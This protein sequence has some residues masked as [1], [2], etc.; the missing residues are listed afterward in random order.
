MANWGETTASAFANS[1]QNAQKI[2]VEKYIKENENKLAMAA[3]AEKFKE[4]QGGQSVEMAK[5]GYN[6]ITDA[7]LTAP[8]QTFDTKNISTIPNLGM[9]QYDSTKKPTLMNTLTPEQTKKLAEMMASGDMAPMQIGPRNI[10]RVQAMLGAK[11]INPNFSPITADLSYVADKSSMTNI[12]TQDTKVN[13]GNT[14]MKIFNSNY[15]SETDTY[16]IPPSLHYEIAMGLARM[17][18][19]TGVVAQQTAE[20]LRQKTAREGLAGAAIYLGFDPKE[21]GGS[22]Q[23]LIRYFIKN[24][25]T[26]A[27]EAVRARGEYQKGK[28]SDYVGIQNQKEVNQRPSN[29]AF[30]SDKAGKWYDKDKKEIK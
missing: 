27:K 4:W 22:T 13:Q 10:P 20:E 8:G 9:F 17:I 28:M 5:A 19:P 7:M 3:A 18:S 1:F 21:V 6:P 16:N 14:L 30:W 23:N 29:A 2:A 15:D 26:Q 12:R 11:E 24:V 25:D